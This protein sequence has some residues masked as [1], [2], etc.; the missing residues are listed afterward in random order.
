M[1]I[2]KTQSGEFELGGEQYRFLIGDGNGNGSFSDLMHLRED[3]QY[4][5]EY[6]I[7]PAGDQIYL[8][9]SAKPSHTDRLGLGNLLVVGR[10]AYDVKVDTAARRLTLAPTE[11]ELVPLKLAAA[12]ERMEMCSRDFEHGVMMIDPGE[13]VKV[14]AGEY[15]MLGYTLRRTGEMDDE[16][17]LTAG[18]TVKTPFVTLDGDGEAILEFGEP[19]VPLARVSEYN[20]K[21]LERE[22]LDEVSV[23]FDVEGRAKELLKSLSRVSGRKS[24]FPM[25]RSKTNMPQEPTYTVYKSTGEMAAQGQFEY[26]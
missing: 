19:F 5:E 7:T 2:S 14:P 9:R 13:V 21:R 3:M 10:H 16:W 11:A 26:G 17:I 24:A 15:R 25:S 8:S 1:R 23:D 22:D 20:R 18:A 4:S 12:P 6:P